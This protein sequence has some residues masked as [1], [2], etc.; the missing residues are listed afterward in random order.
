MLNIKSNPIAGKEFLTTL[1]ETNIAP[2][3]RSF[4]NGWREFLSPQRFTAIL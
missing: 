2:G 1:V 3:D 4:D